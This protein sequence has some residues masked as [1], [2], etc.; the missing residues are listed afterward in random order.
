MGLK[1]HF[2][3]T[4]IRMCLDCL[5]SQSIPIVGSHR[6]PNQRRSISRCIGLETRLSL[7]LLNLG[8]LNLDSLLGLLC[9][10]QS[11]ELDHRSSL[12]LVDKVA[13][14]TTIATIIQPMDTYLGLELAYIHTFR[15]LVKDT[16]VI[17]VMS[18]LAVVSKWAISFR[19]NISASDTLLCWCYN[20]ILSN[21]ARVNHVIIPMSER[22]RLTVL[23]KT[24]HEKLAKH[25]LWQRHYLF[26]YHVEY[27]FSRFG[28]P[29]FSFLGG[30]FVD[31]LVLKE[32]FKSFR[33]LSILGKEYRAFR[34][35]HYS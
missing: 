10:L 34:V 29:E 24:I 33:F 3:Q 4:C 35:I 8:L 9:L 21:L 18:K 25:S 11:R 12:K 14:H 28:F 2:I 1:E 20:Q 26:V 13:T 30:F 19:K 32:F 17:F 6:H 16:Q 23:A 15:R 27:T 22:T 7:G 5:Y 31:L